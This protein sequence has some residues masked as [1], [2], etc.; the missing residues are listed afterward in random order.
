MHA[1]MKAVM[2]IAAF[3]MVMAGALTF[4]T[5]PA[6]ADEKKGPPER[7]ITDLGNNIYRFI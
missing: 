7:S 3:A 2:T 1:T 6:S 5:A 4:A